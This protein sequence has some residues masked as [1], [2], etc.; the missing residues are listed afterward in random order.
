MSPMSKLKLQK[1]PLFLTLPTAGQNLLYNN[2]IRPRLLL[3]RIGIKF[4]FLVRCET[5]SF[6]DEANFEVFQKYS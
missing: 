3:P 1:I 4:W 6:I 2:P 5:G